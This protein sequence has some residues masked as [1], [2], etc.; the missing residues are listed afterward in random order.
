MELTTIQIND[1]EYHLLCNGTALFS[2]YDHFGYD[3][4]IIS[5]IEPNTQA[6][7]DA[8]MYILSALS[9]QGE[10]YRR[11]QGMD[12]GYYLEYKVA[13]TEIMP[14]DVA[15]IKLAIEHAIRAGFVRRHEDNG[16]RDPWLEEIEKKTAISAV[17][18]I[19]GRLSRLSVFRSPRA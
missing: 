16:P 3:K 1:K 14:Y 6:G 2:C 19:I 12:K 15:R 9:I 5:L 4:D 13:L 8:A 18:N 11:Y 7:F 10:M 17:Q